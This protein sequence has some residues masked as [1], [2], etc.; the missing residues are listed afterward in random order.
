M[1]TLHKHLYLLLALLTL[2]VSPTPAFASSV[3]SMKVVGKAR[4]SILFWDIY[5]ST[6]LSSDGKY[7][8]EQTPLALKI[9]Y[10][11]DI[12]AK[13][14]IEQTKEEWQELK[15]SES[16][17]QRWLPLLEGIFPDIKE[18]DI[19]VM[20]LN[21]NKVSEFLYNGQSVGRITD[22]KFGHQFLRIWLDKNCSY[23]KVCNKLRGN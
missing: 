17:I 13:D 1:M 10:L 9:N 5:D 18:G 11:R 21:E 7:Q 4:L 22:P 23:P 8:P 20:H 2:V 12:D 3:D 16:N 19:L 14:L 15:V 6:L